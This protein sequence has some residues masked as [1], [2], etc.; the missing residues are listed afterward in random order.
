MK[1]RY[2]QSIGVFL[3]A[4]CVVVSSAGIASAA[5]F[6]VSEKSVKGLGSAFAGG[7][8]SAEDASTVYY[9]PAGMV[10]LPGIQVEAGLSAIAYSFEATDK[11]SPTVLTP[12]LGA[13]LSGG[14]GG[15]GGMT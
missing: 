7:A 5:G 3:I 1:K 8:A 12:L 11:G 14:N 4:L 9:N 13:N 10:R 6:A 2:G 15:D